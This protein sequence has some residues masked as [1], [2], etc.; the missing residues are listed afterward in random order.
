MAQHWQEPQL[1]LI[2]PQ[3]RNRRG[4]RSGILCRNRRGVSALPGSI[5]YRNSNQQI[6]SPR[7]QR[8]ECRREEPGLIHE[9]ICWASDI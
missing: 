7:E 9:G 6:Q 4:Q 5:K 8:R 1:K 2:D 3:R